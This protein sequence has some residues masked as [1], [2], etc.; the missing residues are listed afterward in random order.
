LSPGG[1]LPRTVDP[2]TFRAEPRGGRQTTAL[3][4]SNAPP[5]LAAVDFDSAPASGDP[6]R[7]TPIAAVI[8]DENI[9]GNRVSSGVTIKKRQVDGPADCSATDSRR[10]GSEG[11]DLPSASGT[12]VSSAAST[13]AGPMADFGCQAGGGAIYACHGYHDTHTVPSPSMDVTITRTTVTG[14]QKH[15]IPCDDP[16]ETSTLVSDT[17]TGIGPPPFSAQNGIRVEFGAPASIE[18]STV[19]GNDYSSPLYPAGATNEWY[20]TTGHTASGFLLYDPVTGTTICHDTVSFN[21]IGIVHL[22]DGTLDAGSESIA[23]THNTVTQSNGYGIIANGAPGSGDS[24]TISQNT[25]NNE[26]SL[27]AGIRGPPGILVDTGTFALSHNHIPGSQ[28]VSAAS[29]G[30]NQT[31]CGT[32]GFSYTCASTVNITT[33]AIR[34]VSGSSSDP[35]TLILRGTSYTQ[36]SNQ[37]ST[38]GVDGGIVSVT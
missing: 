23:I 1:S 30:V 29:N 14:Y 21:Q 36:D 9:S 34:G 7:R 32:S 4:Q 10:Q 8:L 37:L 13:I 11:V 33:A 6:V 27:N 26:H 25:V 16:G 38:V 35:T 20:S 5:T 12:V 18:G 2:L 28:S 15:G 3:I 19:S 17:V 31:I 22:D 24:V